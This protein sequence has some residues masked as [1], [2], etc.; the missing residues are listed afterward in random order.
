MTVD[1]GEMMSGGMRREKR[2]EESDRV[3]NEMILSIACGGCE[4][5]GGEGRVY[6]REVVM[7]EE[8]EEEEE[9]EET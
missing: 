1:G 8:E 9:R 6:G 3:I 2:L 5:E 4:G 7:L